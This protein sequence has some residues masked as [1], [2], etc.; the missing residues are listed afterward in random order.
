MIPITTSSSMTVKPPRRATVWSRLIASLLPSS[1]LHPLRPVGLRLSWVDLRA[2]SPRRGIPD[3]DFP[4]ALVAA[5]GGQAPAVR[6]ERHSQDVARVA[7]EPV[8]LPAG[9]H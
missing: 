4:L 7:A 6:A 3:L 2:P 8:D 9:V 1:G 5:A